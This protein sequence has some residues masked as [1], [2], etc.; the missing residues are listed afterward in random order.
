MGKTHLF[1]EFIPNEVIDSNLYW[2]TEYIKRNP[3][4]QEQFAIQGAEIEKQ[5][6]MDGGRGNVDDTI[7]Y[8]E[9]GQPCFSP[10][11]RRDVELIIIE[12]ASGTF[13]PKCDPF[14]FDSELLSPVQMII[15]EGKNPRFEFDIDGDSAT[16]STHVQSLL[17]YY[18]GVRKPVATGFLTISTID[19]IEYPQN[20]DK[21]M[22]RSLPTI[23]ADLQLELKARQ[24]GDSARAIGLWLWDY[25]QEHGGR[26]RHGVISEA[27]RS[28]REMLRPLGGDVGYYSGSAD[29]VFHNF[30]N[31]TEA[32]IEACQVLPFK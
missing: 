5:Y 21:Y 14:C 6:G 29:K 17:D 9:K 16:I 31:K 23:K 11:R 26:G 12:M 18:R 24:A 10:K 30:F 2:L 7:F 19:G 32:C 25:V 20:E 27:I 28:A 1:Y 4:R 8:D 22:V 15:E 3:G 13:V